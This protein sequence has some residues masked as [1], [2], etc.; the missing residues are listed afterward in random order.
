M[1]VKVEEDIK[2]GMNKW[3]E[4]MKERKNSMRKIEM[5]EEEERIDMIKIESEVL[6]G[7]MEYEMMGGIIEGKEIKIML[8]KEIYVEWLSIKE[9]EKRKDEKNK[10]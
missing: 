7:K 6:W 3:D 8:M 9:K 4:V 10:D 5:K 2:E 1:I